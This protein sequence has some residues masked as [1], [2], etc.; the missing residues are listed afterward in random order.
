M[1]LLHWM[2]RASPLLPLTALPLLAAGPPGR[3]R[4]SA[5]RDAP[6]LTSPAAGAVIAQDDRGKGCAPEGMTS[7]LH[8]VDFKWS[9]V[10]R[11]VRYELIIEGEGEDA[12]GPFYVHAVVADTRKRYTKCRSASPD[13]N[14]YRWQWRVRGLDARFMPG[15]WSAPGKLRYE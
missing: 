6:S 9:P 4:A 15:P 5:V 2:V 8:Q 13:M 11:A 7:L 14:R 3:P 1:S 10:A 12:T